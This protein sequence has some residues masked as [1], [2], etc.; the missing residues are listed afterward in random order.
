MI[1]DRQLT[2]DFWLHEIPCWEHYTEEQAEQA[3]EATALVCQPIRNTFGRTEI[4]SGRFWR[5]GCRARTGSHAH[6]ALDIVVSGG[7]TREA[8]EWGATALMPSGYIGRWIYEPERLNARGQKL[9]GEHIHMAPRSAM[10]AYNGDGRI[11]V[12]EELPD[13]TTYVFQEWVG[14]TYA[15]P[16][17]LEPLE[18][19]VGRGFPWWGAAGILV[20]I[21]AGGAG[22][23]LRN[24]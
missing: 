6:G 8:W 21:F 14:G 7:R 15:N 1:A 12:L 22:V 11:Q 2:R 13:G 16:Y 9:Q 17:E 18:V 4:T 5:N 23:R 19:V 24:A 20:A 3:Q 10:L